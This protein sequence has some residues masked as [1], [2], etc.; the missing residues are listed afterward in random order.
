MTNFE[1]SNPHDSAYVS[2][3]A[4]WPGAALPQGDDDL[5]EYAGVAWHYGAPLNEQRVFDTGVGLIDLSHRR[6]IKVHGPE[7]GVF[8]NNL[9]SQ[10]LSDAPQC[11]AEKKTATSALDLDIQGHILHQVDILAGLDSEDALYLHLPQAQYETFFAFLTRMIFWSKV[12]VEPADLAV[13]TLMGA[14]VPVFPLP[15]SDAIVATAQVPGF[16]TH[17]LDILVHSPELMNIATLLSDAGAVPTGLM[18][19]TAERVRSQQP[20]LSLDLDDKSI[21]HEAARL[22]SDA[23]HLNKG[24]YRGQETVARVENLGR[25]PR[26]LVIVLLDG[27]APTTPKP[28]DPIVSGGRTVG[29][30]GTV[31]QDYELGP[32]ALATIK[33]SALSASNLV[34][35]EDVA[36]AIDP[37]SLP[38]EDDEKA[39]RKAINRLKGLSTD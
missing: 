6:V 16:T 14:G 12:E 1:N 5:P 39:G 38:K 11:L 8:L 10:K 25:P 3:L 33:R 34:V 30:L 7:A 24:C 21:P 35:A 29:K 4:A 37:D 32:V 18:A 17:R 9:L 20:V 2:P 28:G 36:L 31:V 26:S 13:I 23:V 19:F 22:I 15:S 27:S